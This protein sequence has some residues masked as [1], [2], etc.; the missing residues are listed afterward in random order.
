MVDPWAL[1][2]VFSAALVSG[3]SGIAFPALAGPVLMLSYGGAE[4]VLITSIL[5]ISGQV[6]N[7]LLLKRAI[8]YRIA[9][10]LVI[11]GLVGI[12]LGTA[13]LMLV[14][15][16]VLAPAM[17][18]LITATSVVTLVR[19]GLRVTAGDGAAVELAVGFAGGLCGGMVGFSSAVPALWCSLR[20]L[21]AAAQRAIV[22]PY[23]LAAQLVSAT[24]LLSCGVLDTASATACLEFA[25][26][27]IAGNWLGGVLFA[28]TPL[29]AFNRITMTLLALCGIALILA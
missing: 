21:G 13:V 24:L 6:L 15:R 2:G 25:P 29:V 12:P 26:V 5:S 20:G 8:A 3:L 23:I 18:V 14:D 19:P 9:W 22:Q 10:R 4:A 1:A 28:R 16:G 17:G 7:I 27:L 11:P